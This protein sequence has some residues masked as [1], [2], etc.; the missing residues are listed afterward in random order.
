[1]E[2]TALI[3]KILDENPKELQDY[4]NGNENLFGFFIGKLTNV[5]EPINNINVSD[6]IRHYTKDGIRLL[7]QVNEQLCKRKGN[8]ILK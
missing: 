6:H 3:N 8:Y 2:T 7:D 4:L 5:H 1:M